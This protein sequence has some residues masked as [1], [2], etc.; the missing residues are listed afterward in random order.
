M[1]V[2][3]WQGKDVVTGEAVT[4]H[5]LGFH[6]MWGRIFFSNLVI[7]IFFKITYFM[8]IDIAKNVR[9]MQLIKGIQLLKGKTY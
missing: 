4:V 5:E 3:M 2:H 6:A 8:F 1:Q 9:V 7:Y